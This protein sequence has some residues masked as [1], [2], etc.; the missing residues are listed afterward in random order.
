MG[1]NGIPVNFEAT[2]CNENRGIGTYILTCAWWRP[3]VDGLSADSAIAVLWS[4]VAAT[5][6][7]LAMQRLGRREDTSERSSR[8]CMHG[9]QGRGPVNCAVSHN[10]M[11][12]TGLH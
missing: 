10:T 9:Q 12:H 4:T 5:V 7:F 11:L 1:R 2:V 6:A 3:R 8:L